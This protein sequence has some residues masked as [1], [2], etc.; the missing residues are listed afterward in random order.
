MRGYVAMVGD[1]FH[2]GPIDLVRSVR[3]LGYD[4]VVWA[5]SDAE[6]EGYKRTPVM[7]MDER[8]AA[9][10]ACRCVA[11]VDTSMRLQLV[12]TRWE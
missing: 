6:V 4:V 5:H 3:E 10:Q 12:K 9:V 11:K 8:V 2:V 1:L 7:T